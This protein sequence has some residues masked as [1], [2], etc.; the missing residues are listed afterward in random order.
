[1]K[2]TEQRPTSTLSKY[3]EVFWF[4]SDEDD[5]TAAP[6]QSERVLPDGCIEWIFHLG[7]PFQRCIK[8]EWEVQPRSFVAMWRNKMELKWKSFGW[9]RRVIACWGKTRRTK[10]VEKRA[11]PRSPA[12]NCWIAPFD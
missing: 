8:R 11:I 3:L 4:V 7:A 6:G 10:P 9:H 1:M 12:T 2:Y 5:V